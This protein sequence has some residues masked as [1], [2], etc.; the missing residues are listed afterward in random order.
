M[1]SG[2]KE[3]I[4]SLISSYISRG[5]EPDTDTLH[6]INSA[7]GLTV[8]DEI[9]IFIGNGDDG[10]AVV[11]MISSPSESL[12]EEIESLIPP[13]GLS[14]DEIS[15]IEKSFATFPV[16]CPVYFSGRRI[17]L[18]EADSLF[19]HKQILRRLNTGISFNYISFPENPAE[20]F[21]FFRIRTLLRSKRFITGIE[22]SLFVN[23]L[24][25]NYREMKNYSFEELYHLILVCTEL[26][27]STEKKPF[28]IF[29][30]KKYFYENAAAESVEFSRLITTYSMEFIMMKKIQPPLITAEEAHSIINDID[31]LTSTVF[32][33]I[34]PSVRNIIL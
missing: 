21:N 8:A 7:Y 4:S 15:T 33:M 5:L 27:N 3:R 1:E 22:N 19:C 18:S 25:Q 10:G 20:Q 2:Y 13:E 32:G 16:M 34:I 9:S 30:E 14:A 28:E 11:D 31:R 26:L 23:D 6:F 17:I 12:R 24:I 29:S